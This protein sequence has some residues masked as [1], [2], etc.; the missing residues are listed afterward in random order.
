MT[1]RKVISFEKLTGVPPEGLTPA[2]LSHLFNLNF[3]KFIE[4]NRYLPIGNKYNIFNHNVYFMKQGSTDIYV[5]MFNRA[6]CLAP[7][8]DFNSTMNTDV[9][10]LAVQVNW[11]TGKDVDNDDRWMYLAKLLTESK[12]SDAY[13]TKPISTEW[14]KEVEKTG[15]FIRTNVA[16]RY[17]FAAGVLVR[18]YDEHLRWTRLIPNLMKKGILFDHAYILSKTSNI[19]DDLRYFTC[20][21]YQH[22][23]YNVPSPSTIIDLDKNISRLKKTDKYCRTPKIP[24]GTADTLAPFGGKSLYQILEAKYSEYLEVKDEQFYTKFYNERD[25]VSVLEM[26]YYDEIVPK[27]EE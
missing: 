1:T 2:V 21:G 12:F 13:L 23:I 24:R 20:I 8:I 27:L 4:D 10:V 14:H 3:R 5:K 9:T 26:Y 15:V 25:V 7:L 11:M 17:M 22:D 19:R 18:A 6:I 16:S